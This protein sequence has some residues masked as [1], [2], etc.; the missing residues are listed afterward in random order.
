MEG[1]QVSHRWCICVASHSYSGLD[2]GRDGG[3]WW[4]ACG[5]NPRGV[6]ACRERPEDNTL[7]SPLHTAVQM[8]FS[9]YGRAGI[10]LSS[11]NGLHTGRHETV[12]VRYAFCRFAAIHGAPR[13]H[14]IGVVYVWLSSCINP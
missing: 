9:G 10:G 11:W 14:I 4:Y 6:V 13:T 2:A 8:R 3:G 5:R 7:I 12:P 1:G